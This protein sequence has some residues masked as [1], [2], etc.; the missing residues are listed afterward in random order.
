MPAVG[1]RRATNQRLPSGVRERG[2]TWYWQ[3]TR[4]RERLARKKLRDDAIA[5]G[6]EPEPVEIT[7]GPAGTPETRRK[8]AEVSGYADPQTVDGTVGELLGSWFKEA[9]HKRPNGRKRAAETVRTYKAC[10]PA[11][12]ERF[13]AARYGRTEFEASRGKAIG[14]ADIQSFVAECESPSMGNL[15]FAILANA[16]GYAVRRG[17][18]VYDPCEKVVKNAMDARTREPLEWE[19]EAL[20]TLARPLLGLLMDYEGITGDRINEILALLNASCEAKGIRVKRSKRGR[21]EIWGWSPELTRIVEE[22]ALLPGAT[23]FPA[24]PLFPGR[25]GKRFT[26]SGFDTAWQALKRKANAALAEG[27]VDPDTLELR[28]AL[29]IEDLHFHDLRSKAHDD[30]EDAGRAGNEQ[31]GNTTRVARVHYARR[32]KV[33]P[34]LR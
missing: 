14:T 22:A 10:Y 17:R 25:R 13:A 34:P 33:K 28:A 32:E 15:Y 19:V 24:S 16:F 1:R 26:Y 4:L 2:A 27:M 9:L 6:E 30:A 18:T 7:L 8:W 11:V 12:L 5:K 31:L 3:P 21:P 20:R 23:K 29:V